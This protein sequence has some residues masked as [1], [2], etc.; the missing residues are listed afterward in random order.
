MTRARREAI[1]IY[2]ADRPPCIA[3]SIS[4]ASLDDDPHRPAHYG[5]LGKFLHAGVE[6]F[7]NLNDTAD[8][9]IPTAISDNRLRHTMIEKL[10]EAFSMVRDHSDMRDIFDQLDASQYQRYLLNPAKYDAILDNM[11]SG[12]TTFVNSAS[13]LYDRLEEILPGNDRAIVDAWRVLNDIARL[14][15]HQ[16]LAFRTTYLEAP[17]NEED[18]FSFAGLLVTDPNDASG[19]PPRFL[20][21]MPEEAAIPMHAL[22]AHVSIPL[23]NP[24]GDETICLAD[25]MGDSTI[26][27][28]VTFSPE[29]VKRL[30]EFYCYKRK[31][32]ERGYARVMGHYA[33]LG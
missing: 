4:E 33:T 8:R 24:A 30:W 23:H 9:R 27:C 20:P 22:D 32:M 17:M 26:G 6:E 7:F 11:R 18:E 13:S 25:I 31:Q 19:E 28:P 2:R 12:S 21:S 5:Y 1:Q 16:F 14:N 3:D 10:C 15:I 29:D